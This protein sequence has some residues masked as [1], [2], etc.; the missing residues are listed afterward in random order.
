MTSSFQTLLVQWFDQ[1]S[2]TP[3]LA[4]PASH[5]QQPKE[6]Q[7]NLCPTPE[8]VHLVIYLVRMLPCPLQDFLLLC[9]SPR[10]TP[11]IHLAS[12]FQYPLNCREG[13]FSL[14]EKKKKISFTQ[15]QRPALMKKG[16]LDAYNRT[17]FYTIT[18]RC[19]VRLQVMWSVFTQPSA[20]VLLPLTVKV[21]ISLL[22]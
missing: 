11:Q 19:N 17:Q 3:Q 21:T 7:N 15:V 1:G 14:N 8:L 4:P 5:T 12:D 6:L 2:H 20:R 18:P 10:A 9:P 13:T 22:L 16:Y